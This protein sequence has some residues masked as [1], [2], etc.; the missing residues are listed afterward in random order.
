MESNGSDDALDY[1]APIDFKDI[2]FY[3]LS[4]SLELKNSYNVSPL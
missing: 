3:A 4:D 2:P 1:D